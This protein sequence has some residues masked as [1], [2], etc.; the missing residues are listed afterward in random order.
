MSELARD[1]EMRH[2]IYVTEGAILNE[3]HPRPIS[4]NALKTGRENRQKAFPKE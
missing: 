1:N 4:A 3:K 2:R